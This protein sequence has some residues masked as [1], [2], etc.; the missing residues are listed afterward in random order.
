METFGNKFCQK[1]AP[2]FYCKFCDYG[3]SK[4]SSYDDHILSAKHQKH[5]LGNTIATN[6]GHNS[7]TF[8]SNLPSTFTCHNC[9]REFKTR[10]G[11]WKH[12]KTCKFI[13]NSVN[14]T[15]FQ[16]FTDVI[17]TTVIE[18]MK[19]GMVTNNSHNNTNNS[20]NKT[21]NLSFYLNETCKDAINIGDFVKSIKVQL[22]DLEHNGRVGY[23]EGV[24]DIIINNLNSID[25]HKRPIHCTD[26]KREVLYIKNDGEWVKESDNKSIIT[27]A[28]KTIANENIKAISQWKQT[29]PDCTNV[30][31]K[32]N[33][34][35]LKI[36]SNSMSGGSKEECEKNYNK[37]IRNI[38]KETI[39]DKDNC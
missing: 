1:S 20:H 6:L 8:C 17:K 26:E 36:V 4:K 11:L 13:D 5:T 14:N 24:S 31:S 12:T 19:N 28:I 2:R 30:D 32:K 16:L 39:I 27:N 21:F 3:T 35:Y 7:A 23:V 10:S 25:T 22:E 29:Y 38:V 9:D 34:L 37:I 15:Q 18:V 33:N